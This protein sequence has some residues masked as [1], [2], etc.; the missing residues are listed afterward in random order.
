MSEH[1]DEGGSPVCFLPNVCPA[2][3]RLAT[4]EPRPDTCPECGAD[5]PEPY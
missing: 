2:C 3:G 4:A 1:D 5:L